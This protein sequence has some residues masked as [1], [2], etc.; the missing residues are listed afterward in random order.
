VHFQPQSRFRVDGRDL[1]L[2]LPVAPWEAAL[3]ATIEIPL[4]AGDAV[5]VRIPAGAQSGHE[6]KV[7][8]RGIPGQPPGDL[9]LE[10][11]V[12]LPGAKTPQA[13]ALYETMARELAFD[14]RGHSGA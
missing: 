1:H 2:A 4:P 12:V 13:R 5:K 14:P 6:L 8:A 7:K 3:G 11:R 10:I 9:Y